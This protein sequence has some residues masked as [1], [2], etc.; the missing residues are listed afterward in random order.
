MADLRIVTDSTDPAELFSAYRTYSERYERLCDDIDVI[1][2][3]LRFVSDRKEGQRLTAELTVLTEDSAIA[4][5]WV[6]AAFAAY[7]FVSYG[8]AETGAAENDAVSL[9]IPS[10][11]PPSAARAGGAR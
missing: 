6:A 11:T 10:M 4:L 5:G 7:I 1:D 3:R 2:R 9:V 8:T